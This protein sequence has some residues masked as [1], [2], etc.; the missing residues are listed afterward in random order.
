MR[1]LIKRN[2]NGKKIL[3]LFIL[4]SIVYTIMLTITVPK[5]MSFSGGMKLLDM[6]PTGYNSSY[7]NSLLNTLGEKGRNAYLYNQLPIDMIF[8]MLFGISYCLIFAFFLNKLKKLESNLFYICFLPLFSGFFDYCEN[9]GII[10]MLNIYPD[11]LNILA[12]TT[13]V[14]SVLKSSFTTIY[15]IILI[16]L[17]IVF[18]ISKLI[19]KDK[20]NK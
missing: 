11:N 12:Q 6:I 14:F 1:N 17:I 18:G 13:N 9:I 7:V 5:V 19:R 3:I 4:T 15:F 10:T 8:P 20:L 2:L 16:T